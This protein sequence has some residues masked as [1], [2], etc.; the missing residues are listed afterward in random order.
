MNGSCVQTLRLVCSKNV[1]RR[2][3]LISLSNYTS[4]CHVDCSREDH[5]TVCIVPLCGLD[6]LS[7]PVSGRISLLVSRKP[8][9]LRV[10]VD[11][12]DQSRCKRVSGTRRAFWATDVI[13]IP[14]YDPVANNE[15]PRE[16]CVTR[17]VRRSLNERREMSKGHS[18]SMLYRQNYRRDF[19]KLGFINTKCWPSLIWVCIDPD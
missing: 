18:V 5:W 10:P 2:L 15:R 1:V 3:R 6:H 19:I 7:C 14:Q 16:P 11:T 8:C 17:I 9:M 4:Y 13:W 12:E